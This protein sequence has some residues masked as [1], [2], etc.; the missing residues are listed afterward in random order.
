M[1]NGL[2]F[3]RVFSSSS[4]SSSL[5]RPATTPFEAL[6]RPSEVIGSAHILAGRRRSGI[7]GV[8]R[9]DFMITMR[10]RGILIARAGTIV[11]C[12]FFLTLCWTGTFVV[13]NNNYDEQIEVE[14]LKSIGQIFCRVG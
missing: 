13:A 10:K 11:A 7:E 9:C 4:S 6:P 3:G 2:S 12:S 14:S 5:L 1:N 8:R